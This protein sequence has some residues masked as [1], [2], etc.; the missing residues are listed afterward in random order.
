MLSN[1]IN[2]FLAISLII[3]F[4]II[5]IGFGYWLTPEYQLSMYDKTT[6]DLGQADRWFDLRYINA[7]ISHHRGA[8]LMAEKVASQTKKQ[9]IKDLTAEIIKN[10]PLAIDELYKWKK[11][12]YNDSRKV[13]D[14]IIPNFG[15]YDEKYDLRFLNALISHHQAGIVMVKEARLKSNRTEILNNVDAVEL[16][17]TNSLKTLTEW[18]KTWYQI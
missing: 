17:L 13:S 15:S 18:R 2:S 3:I 1:K 10:E 4:T 6:M 16:F 9:E 5:G 11:D 8:V 14:P 12:W 7:M